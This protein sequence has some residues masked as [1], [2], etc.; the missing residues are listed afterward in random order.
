VATISQ[1]FCRNRIKPFH[2]LTPSIQVLLVKMI[3]MG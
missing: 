3:R 1:Q 2:D